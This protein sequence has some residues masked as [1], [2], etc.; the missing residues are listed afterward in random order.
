[1]T[2]VY[3]SGTGSETDAKFLAHQRNKAFPLKFDLGP[4]WASTLR[5]PRF[6]PAA[7][8]LCLS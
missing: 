1:M 4:G 8:V 6:S 7:L 3:S 5:V 2:I